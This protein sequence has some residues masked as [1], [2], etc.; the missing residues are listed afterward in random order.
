MIIIIGA[1][2]VIVCV[3]GGFLMEGGQLQVII[4]ATVNEAIIIA[5]GAEAAIG[6]RNAFIE[7]IIASAGEGPIVYDR[8]LRCGLAIR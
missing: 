7:R 1:I 4:H 5:G 3:F 8:Y 2:T 6:E